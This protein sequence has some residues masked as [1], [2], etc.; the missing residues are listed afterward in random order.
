MNDLDYRDSGPRRNEMEDGNNKSE[1][2][3]NEEFEKL[4]AS[5]DAAPTPE[6]SEEGKE[7]E[8]KPAPKSEEKPADDKKPEETDGKTDPE[9]KT[10]KSEQDPEPKKADEAGIGKALK[11]TKAWGT[12]LAQENSELKKLVEEL[13]A[14]KATQEQV[15]QAKDKIGET[16]KQ[17]RDRLNKTYEDYPELKESLDPL[18][19]LIEGVAADVEN[20]KKSSDETKARIAEREAFEKEVAP[21]IA[22]VH[23]DF[24]EIA[25][26][27]DYVKWAEAQ[28]P[29]MQ[30][31]ALHSRDP[32]DINSALA[33]FKK[34]RGSDESKKQKLDDEARRDGV[35]KNL[36]STRGG[37][38]SSDSKGKPSRLGDVDKDDYNGAWDLMASKEK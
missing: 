9:P 24:R 32:R 28:S 5:E 37:G 31:A 10:E 15:N 16:K 23:P 36:S 3:Y 17:I 29:A 34:F 1:Q 2:E 27:D 11:D 13:K 26:S 33:E 30:V 18:V 19:T 38:S 20:F 6:K 7:P 22:A 8:Q 35:R 25:A 21:H 4:A 14:G 12:K